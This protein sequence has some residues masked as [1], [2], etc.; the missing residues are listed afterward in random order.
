MTRPD[1]LD[2][3]LNIDLSREQR[4]LQERHDRWLWT[5]I[6]ADISE[7]EAKEIIADLQKPETKGLAA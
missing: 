3:I 1:E 5:L 2:E 4:R 6:A 7:A